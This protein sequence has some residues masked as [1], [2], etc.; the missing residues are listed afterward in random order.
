MAETDV[1]TEALEGFASRLRNAASGLEGLSAPPDIPDAGEDSGLL[2][3]MLSHFTSSMKSASTGTSAAGDAV[4][5]SR[6]VFDE[7]E[8]GAKSSFENLPE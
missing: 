4:A 7:V 8:G 3:S 1:S 5:S 6:N 2:A